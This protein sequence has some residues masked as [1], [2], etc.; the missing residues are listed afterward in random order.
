MLYVF[1]VTAGQESMIA[2]LLNAKLLKTNPGVKSLIVSPYLKGYILVEGDNPIELKAMAGDIRHIKG[3]LNRSMDISEIKELLESKPV[4][5]IIN[6]DDLIEVISGPFKGEKAKVVRVD[7]EK[8]EV[9]VELV[10]VAVP[11]PVTIKK[12]AIKI[13][14]AANAPD[15]A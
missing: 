15:K 9:T 6:K 8:E 1:R 2:D 10:E 5:I 7:R 4:E 3:V 12:S 11:I 14:Q 13:I